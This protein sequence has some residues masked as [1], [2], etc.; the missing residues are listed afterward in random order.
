MPKVKQPQCWDVN[1]IY[2]LH[3]VLL[4]IPFPC[5][6]FVGSRK[7]HLPPIR[8]LS[9]GIQDAPTRSLSS[10]CRSQMSPDRQSSPSCHRS[11]VPSLCLERVG[12]SNTGHAHQQRQVSLAVVSQD[13]G[14]VKTI[15][16]QRRPSH[17]CPKLGLVYAGASGSRLGDAVPR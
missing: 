15:G 9:H 12:P 13:I 11:S 5:P 16:P 4:T 2:Q 17:S 6:L 14:L 1:S 10:A 7:R 3:E 8:E